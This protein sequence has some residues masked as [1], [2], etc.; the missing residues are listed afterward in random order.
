[1]SKRWN[2]IFGCRRWPL[3]SQPS[4]RLFPHELALEYKGRV[5]FEV[6]QWRGYNCQNVARDSVV[7]D[8]EAWSHI[9]GFPGAVCL[10]ALGFAAAMA[11]AVP[12]MARTHERTREAT[13]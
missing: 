11:V 10:T 9:Y 3:P 7:K 1:M 5:K 8:T 2:R 6:A 13:R 4:G 12:L